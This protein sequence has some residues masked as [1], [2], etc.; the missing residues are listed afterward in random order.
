MDTE[1]VQLIM[2]TLK[3]EMACEI[4]ASVL[5]NPKEHLINTQ[6]GLI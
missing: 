2:S 6:E 5:S 3:D 4:V 1:S